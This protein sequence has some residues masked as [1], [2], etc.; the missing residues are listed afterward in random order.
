[1]GTGSKA[2][3]NMPLGARRQISGGIVASRVLEG[4]LPPRFGFLP[5]DFLDRPFLSSAFYEAAKPKIR[6]KATPTPS[7][8]T[9]RPLAQAPTRSRRCWS[10]R[11]RAAVSRAA[12]GAWGR[13]AGRG[14]WSR[15]ARAAATPRGPSARCRSGAGPWSRAARRTLRTGWTT[16]RSRT[17]PAAVAA[18]L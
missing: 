1:M 10:P 6:I 7:R 16:C 15:C 18:R 2:C 17:A 9:S 14:G 5:F 4:S 3:R 12:C 13:A 8:V 11:R